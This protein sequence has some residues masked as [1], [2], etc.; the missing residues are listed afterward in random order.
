MKE[1]LEKIRAR[2]LKR[3]MVKLREINTP[4][5]TME[6]VERGFNYFYMDMSDVITGT[7]ESNDQFNK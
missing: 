6:A 1:K 7:K 3:L 5:I 2:Q 4:K